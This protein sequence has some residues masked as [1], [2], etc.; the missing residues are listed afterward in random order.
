LANII[1]T[2][3]GSGGDVLPFIEIGRAL[4]A[5]GHRVTLFS[6]GYYRSLAENTGLDF[7][8][9]DGPEEYAQFLKDE[10]LLN[11]PRGVAEFLGRHSLP[12][13]LLEYRL[14]SERCGLGDTILVSRDLFDTA[15]RIAG[16]KLGIR[17]L[18]VFIAP[19]QA[20]TW[21]I[22]VE[23]F[24]HAL[25]S[26][27]NRLRAQLNLSPVEDWYSWLG[28]S[29]PSIALWPDW[30]GDP[31]ATWPPGLMPVGFM[32]D[33]EPETVELGA[34]VG[35]ILS[36]GAPHI[37]IT[38]GT[39]MYLGSEF[40]AAAA[41]AC[42]LLDRQA[43]LIVP[44][45]EQAPKTLPDS[46]R[47]FSYLPFSKVMPQVDAVIHHGGRG[48]LSRAIAAGV[49]QL[50]LAM[51]ADR[52]DNAQRLKRLGVAD[53]LPPP[54]W[55]ADRVAAALRRLMGS[56][57]VKN[58]CKELAARLQQCDATTAA[59]EIIEEVV[60]FSPRPL[61]AQVSMFPK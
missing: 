21:S 45:E 28:Y 26:D 27:I 34:E 17:L 39:G 18:H 61:K 43:I 60:R 36:S 59:C 14:V 41:E 56:S 40:Y 19:S 23:L 58:R 49:P 22:R 24:I 37:L 31:N 13:V 54:H 55:T 7:A 6:H 3:L 29:S 47:R 32:A 5:C 25:A 50:V 30:F 48:T 12:K 53:C 8:A 4:K 44:H 15:A 51:G 35:R 42:R 46:V 16:E 1:F 38:A 9:L 33:C 10:P 20:A 57:V 11:S 52:P 2:A